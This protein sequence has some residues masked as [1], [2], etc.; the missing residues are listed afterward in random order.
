MKIGKTHRFLRKTVNVR[1]ADPWVSG[2][3]K[4]GVPLIVSQ[5]QHN[6]GFFFW[7]DFFYFQYL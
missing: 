5:H 3:A 7:H 2:A 6:V 1:G 4:V